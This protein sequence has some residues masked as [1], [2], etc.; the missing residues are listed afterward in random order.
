MRCNNYDFNSLSDPF[1]KLAIEWNSATPERRA[2]IEQEQ[3]QLL[4]RNAITI[5]KV[6]QQNEAN[7]QRFRAGYIAG[8]IEKEEENQ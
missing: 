4:A 1:I 2:E 7:Y 5:E 3:K 8:R 6:K